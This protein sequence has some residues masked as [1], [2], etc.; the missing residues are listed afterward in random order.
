[1]QL[2]YGKYAYEY[3]YAPNENDDAINKEPC[4][5]S[6]WERY[7]QEVTYEKG[8]DGIFRLD[9]NIECVQI[10]NGKAHMMGTDNYVS[11]NIGD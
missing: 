7:P 9:G 11:F 3:V 5:V 2:P 1:M 8:W 4:D 6:L 10:K